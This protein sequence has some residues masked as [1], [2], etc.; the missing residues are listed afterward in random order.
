M[1]KVSQARARIA[2]RLSSELGIPVC[3]IARH[4]GGVYF[5]YCQGHQNVESA[6]NK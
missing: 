5:C 1:R 2:Y 6:K 4:L 3:E